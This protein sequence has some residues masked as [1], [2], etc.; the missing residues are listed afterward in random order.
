ML[1]KK[2]QQDY[3]TERLEVIFHNYEL[4][5]KHTRAENIHKVRV[6]L[7]KIRALMYLQKKT[8]GIS[9]ERTEKLIRK[10]FG[11]A[12]K[13]R[14]AQ[15]SAELMKKYKSG[16]QHFFSDQKKTVA[17]ESKELV[18]T[19]NRHTDELIKS[20]DRQ[21]KSLKK[22]PGKKIETL[23]TK[24]IGKL[25]PVFMPRLQLSR[26]HESR[27]TIKRLIYINTLLKR[28][29]SS[30]IN[31][32]SFRKLEEKIGKWHDVVVASKLVQKYGRGNATTEALDIQEQKLLQDVRAQSR[33]CFR[34][35]SK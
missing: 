23:N 31:T 17:K 12:G 25:R 13:I 7:K 3:F 9:D 16:N 22:I 29:D 14:D 15:V 20:C 34:N 27:K 6:A 18:R 35:P 28:D 19:V 4:F 26:L 8:L 30:R 2:R 5:S 33:S 21:W 10:L 32:D 1:S 24:M 11:Q